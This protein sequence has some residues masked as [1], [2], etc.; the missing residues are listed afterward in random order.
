MRGKF[1][2]KLVCLLLIVFAVTGCVHFNPPASNDDD[3]KTAPSKV[4]I[5]TWYGNANGAFVITY[6]DGI[7]RSLIKFN[8][9]QSKDDRNI[10]ATM[11]LVT[12]DGWIA[13]PIYPT[14]GG[15]VPNGVSNLYDPHYFK[16]HIDLGGDGSADSEALAQEWEDYQYWLKYPIDADW[17]D[18][19]DLDGNPDT[20]RP[21]NA[22]DYLSIGT[23]EEF[24]QLESLGYIDVCSHSE[25]HHHEDELDA[26]GWGT[27]F[28]NSN[29][30]I[31][32]HIGKPARV[33]IVPYY[34]MNDEYKEELSQYYLA[35]RTGGDDFNDNDTTDY[36]NLLSFTVYLSPDAQNEYAQWGQWEEEVTTTTADDI[37]EWIDGAAEGKF[38]ILTGHGLNDPDCEGPQYRNSDPGAYFEWGRGYIDERDDPTSVDGN[39]ETT[40]WSCGVRN[41]WMPTSSE[42]YDEAYAYLQEKMDEGVV[43]NDFYGDVIEYLRERQT[44]KVSVAEDGGDEMVLA[45]GAA[46]V[47]N[48]ITCDHPLTLRVVVPSTWT[49]A[50]FA[51]GENNGE[52]EVE[53]DEGQTV[54]FVDAIPGNGNITLR[55][56]SPL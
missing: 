19:T 38:A 50:T 15:A 47:I 35:A 56:A 14:A 28:E 53:T 32:A 36:Y 18:Y 39:D 52:V 33:Y 31:L 46:P 7:F 54:V 37:K 24:L 27:Q 23:W 22:G 21:V 9:L 34:D 5:C 17:S 29:A 40:Y 10:K 11:G 20:N 8:E 1:F 2:Q 6:D 43:W 44:V 55:R 42:V 13:N 41:L 49:S 16:E 4:S 12:G 45:I 3:G 48:G 26:E 25:T 30:D 51:Q